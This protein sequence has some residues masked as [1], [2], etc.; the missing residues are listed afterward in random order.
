MA[1]LDDMNLDQG[2]GEDSGTGITAPQPVGLP[3]MTIE[4]D[5]E[6]VSPDQVMEWKRGYMR[7]DAFTKKTQE[8]SR[9]RD[10]LT[11][12]EA[13]VVE[14]WA[15]L[16]P[17]LEKR[18]ASDNGRT[19]EVDN[20]GDAFDDP[21]LSK[22]ETFEKRFDALEQREAKRDTEQTFEKMH[23]W[24]Q[25][26]TSFLNDEPEQF[27][28][29]HLH[30]IANILELVRQQKGR[31]EENDVATLAR[32]YHEAL[33]Q[34]DDARFERL[35]TKKTEVAAKQPAAGGAGAGGPGLVQ[36]G[37]HKPL[38]MEKGMDFRTEINK[39]FK[40]ANEAAT[41]MLKQLKT[42]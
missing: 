19:R 1:R 31:V 25:K 10:A 42:G 5:G 41:E 13:Q 28:A 32:S 4:V 39:R 18:R 9:Q 30:S 7:Q 34:R 8:L 15:W 33:K 22:L 14:A 36:R 38:K 12:R 26:H 24:M 23:G 29:W 6:R 27:R 37:G 20:V 11:E 2:G 21:V 17:Q 16:K 40:E 3:D 35:S